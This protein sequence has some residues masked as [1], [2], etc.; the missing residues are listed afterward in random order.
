M[1]EK[2]KITALTRAALFEIVEINALSGVAR[3]LETCMYEIWTTI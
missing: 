3:W 1:S 2:F